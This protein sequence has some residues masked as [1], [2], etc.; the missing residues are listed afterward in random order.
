MPSDGAVSKVGIGVLGVSGYTGMEVLRLLLAHPNAE[1]LALGSRQHKGQK[2]G[3][4]L[5]AMPYLD[6]PIDD[7]PIDPTPWAKR[8]VKTVFAAL[9]HGAFAER[10]QNFLELG[11]RLVD[12]SADFRLHNAADY[13]RHYHMEHPARHLLADAVYGLTEW[14]T[15]QS[16]RAAQLVA[17]PGCY[18]T[19][20]LLSVLPMIS[21]GE[22]N[23]AP[24]VV[25]AMSG[26]S[27]AGRAAKQNTHFVECGNSLSPYKVGESHSHLGEITQAIRLE[28]GLDQASVIFNP[29]LVPMARGIITTTTLPLRRAWTQNDAVE[30]F[31][32]RYAQCPFVHVLDGDALPETRFVRSSNRCDIAVRVVAGGTMLLVM[33]AIDNLVKGAAGQAVQNWNVMYG[34]DE[35]TGVPRAGL[36]VG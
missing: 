23:G 2:L 7:D 25:N 20:T 13:P 21:S 10:A 3:S 30:L 36:A 9:P 4:I 6:L 16:L 18:P 29:H 31:K 8:G 1:I 19:A 12:L 26:V 27:G 35:T 17:N 22:W 15:P 33:A 11:I 14:C 28:S 24:I 5:P 32:A 34:F